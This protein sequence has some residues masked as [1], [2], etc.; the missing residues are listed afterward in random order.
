MIDRDP[1]APDQGCEPRP[2]VCGANGC[3]PAG[4]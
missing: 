4:C 3:G 2:A 1:D